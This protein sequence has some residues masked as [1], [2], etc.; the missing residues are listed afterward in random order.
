M[1]TTCCRFAARIWRCNGWFGPLLVL[2]AIASSVSASSG[3]RIMLPAWPNKA[4]GLV[5]GGMM[6][7]PPAGAP[8]T[9]AAGNKTGLVLT[10][11]TTWVDGNG[12]R[13]VRVTIVPTAPTTADRSLR[14]SFRPGN[15][16]AP[17]VAVTR[18]IELPAGFN[19]VT[20]TLSV[21]QFAQ[22]NMITFDVFED[23]EYVRELSIP[24]RSMWIGGS[25]YWGDNAS[26]SILALNSTVNASMVLNSLGRSGQSVLQVGAANSVSTSSVYFPGTPPRQATFSLANAIPTL[27]DLPETWID[28]SGLDV[29]IASRQDLQTLVEQHKSQWRAIRQWILSGGNLWVYGVGDPKQPNWSQ[30]NLQNDQPWKHLGNVNE[31]IGFPAST[32]A[33]P[34]KDSHPELSGW[35]RP[36]PN[37]VLTQPNQYASSETRMYVNGQIVYA[38]SAQMPVV[39]TPDV[40][41]GYAFAADVPKDP[42]FPFVM[43]PLGEGMVVAIPDASP[44]TNSY[45]PWQTVISNV[46]PERWHWSTRNGVNFSST[47]ETYWNFLIPGVGTAPVTAFQVLITLFVLAIG[48]LNFYVLKR[49]HKLNL[50][51][52]TVPASAAVVTLSLLAYA[53][54]SDGFGVRARTR[55]YTQL[56]QRTGEATCLGRITYYAGLTPGKGLSFSGD[57]T[58][59]PLDEQP[60]G[61]G[62]EAGQTRRLA[63]QFDE[64]DGRS[65]RQNL[66]SGWIQSRIQTQLMTVRSRTTDAKLVFANENGRATSVLNQLGVPISLLLVHDNTGG[67]SKAQNVAPETKS[68]LTTIAARDLLSQWEDLRAENQLRPPDGMEVTGS[69]SIFDIRRRNYRRAY[70]GPRVTVSVENSR[71]ERALEET[72]V[73][74]SLGQLPRGSYVAVVER[75]PEFELGIDSATEESS[76]HIIFGRW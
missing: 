72:L 67:F 71:L 45:F 61:D 8:M 42:K 20:T 57:I 23:G 9:P 29:I 32:E 16:R 28:Y 46:G 40:G 19:S 49:W 66:E 33:S 11:D 44:T 3:F 56:D 22:W 74:A 35:R 60:S 75:S 34:W 25:Q 6:A 48:P 68:E 13:P 65:G 63:W 31:N 37:A 12:Y 4:G 62:F 26:P 7:A 5:P 24:Q 36:D 55:S 43:R 10:L 59:Y 70:M 73:A 21:P 2:L 30:W 15:Y 47:N 27:A 52:I 1:Q 64:D 39:T 14:V 38:P 50:L 41:Q 69:Q 53:V 51:L 18:D 17:S 58:V 76:F 54:F